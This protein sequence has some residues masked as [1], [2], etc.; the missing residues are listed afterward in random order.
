MSATTYAEDGGETPEN[1]LMPGGFVAGTVLARDTL[2]DAAE[3]EAV[4]DMAETFA[5]T[6]ADAGVEEA[7]TFYEE[8]RDG[9]YRPDAADAVDE[10]ALDSYWNVMDHARDELAPYIDSLADE[11]TDTSVSAFLYSEEIEDFYRDILFDADLAEDLYVMDD[12]DF[13]DEE[14]RQEAIAARRSKVLDMLEQPEAYALLSD[15]IQDATR[16]IR[17]RVDDLADMYDIDAPDPTDPD[18]PGDDPTDPGD[19]ADADDDDGAGWPDDFDISFEYPG[20]EEEGVEIDQYEPDDTIPYKVRVDNLPDNDGYGY[21]LEVRLLDGDGEYWST[22]THIH[23]HDR[24]PKRFYSG[25]DNGL[26]ELDLGADGPDNR[27]DKIKHQHDLDRCKLEARVIDVE[28]GTHSE[29]A[30]TVSHFNLDIPEPE[31]GDDGFGTFT[32]ILTSVAGITLAHVGAKKV[33]EKLLNFTPSG[34]G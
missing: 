17:D 9:A 18:A 14:A 27:L 1:V 20:V 32:N 23:G 28:D 34:G 4:E 29:L 30:S 26:D 10:A 31:S 2:A 11:E 15:T 7:E 6:L 5:G 12:E 22:S 16:A 33:G 8:I 24:S 25:G 3:Y 21:K 19:P 13:E